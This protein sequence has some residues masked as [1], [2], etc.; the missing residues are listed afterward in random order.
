MAKAERARIIFSFSFFTRQKLSTKVS[1]FLLYSFLGPWVR[2]F[3]LPTLSEYVERT[4]V[5]SSALT[6]SLLSLA[7]TLRKGAVRMNVPDDH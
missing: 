5:P 7:W 6:L 2:P 3:P 1:L 4:Y